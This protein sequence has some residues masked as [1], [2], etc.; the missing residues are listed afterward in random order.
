M[1]VELLP[2]LQFGVGL[3]GGGGGGSLQSICT[4]VI[5]GVFEHSVLHIK[6]IYGLYGP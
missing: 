2:R 6:E 3:G 4:Q 1:W 5:S